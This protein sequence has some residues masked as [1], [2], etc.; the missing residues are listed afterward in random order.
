M[1]GNEVLVK[2]QHVN[3]IMNFQRGT[4]KYMGLLLSCNNRAFFFFKI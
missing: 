2:Q 4:F 1:Y 3:V